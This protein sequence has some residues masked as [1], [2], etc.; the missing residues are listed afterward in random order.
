MPDMR[1]VDQASPIL[2][3]VDAAVIADPYAP[4]LIRSAQLLYA[5]WSRV[6]PQ[7]VDGSPHSFLNIARQLKE[8]TLG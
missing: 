4:Q 1:D 3:P 6:A 5:R 8:L 7:F 2:N